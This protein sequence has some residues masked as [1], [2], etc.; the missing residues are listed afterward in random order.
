M[1]FPEEEL[2]SETVLPLFDPARAVLNRNVSLK[3]RFEA[4]LGIS[5]GLDEPFRSPFYPTGF[6]AFYFSEAHGVSL[7]GTWFL[8]FYSSAGEKL[9]T[10]KDLC[11][12][13]SKGNQVRNSRDCV[14]YQLFD[15]HRVPYPQW[16]AFLNYQY[17]PY[18]GKISLT[19]NFVMNLSIYG[20]AGPGI[21]ILHENSR[22]LAFNLGIG[23]RL[24]LN[25][26]FG[27]RTDIGLYGY[28]G[29]DPAKI[30]I[31]EEVSHQEL[32]QRIKQQPALIP[33]QSITSD[34]K[35]LWLHFTASIGAVI[36]L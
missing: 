11:L 13:D 6:L 22:L 31:Y 8:P 29:P 17:T 12:K 2:A 28:Y 5:F 4:G 14:Q 34:Q 10:G 9:K 19:K 20:F 15:V 30:D 32:P 33:F 7:T 18:Y 23:Q 27:L 21:I 16:M 3:Y 35:T 25:R 1:R 24:Y 36:L 26:Y